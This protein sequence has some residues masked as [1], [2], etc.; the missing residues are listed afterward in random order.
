[1]TYKN[2]IFT[3]YNQAMEQRNKSTHPNQLEK[4]KRKHPKHF[5][6][7]SG[8]VYVSGKYLDT[9]DNLQTALSEFKNIN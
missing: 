4:R 2:Q 6:E 1:M 5:I 9:L 8:V 3:P 7:I